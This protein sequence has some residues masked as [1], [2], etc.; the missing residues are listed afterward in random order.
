V[1]DGLRT[2]RIATLRLQVESRFTLRI[3]AVQGFEITAIAAAADVDEVR[4]TLFANVR[5]G[6]GGA[7]P[8]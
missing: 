2:A 1:R 5:L 8:A 6:L 3:R 4:Q 7:P